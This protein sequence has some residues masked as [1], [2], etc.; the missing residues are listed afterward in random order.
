MAIQ[1]GIHGAGGRMGQ[2][3]VALA[4]ADPDFKLVAALEH[5]SH[6]KLGADAG[7]A[8]GV[9]ANWYS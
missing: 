6:A 1:L 7:L 8:A 4:S 2:R 5:A 3:L 9:M